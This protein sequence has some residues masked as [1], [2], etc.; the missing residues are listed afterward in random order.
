MSAFAVRVLSSLAGL[1]REQP[2]LARKPYDSREITL[3]LTAGLAL[4][5]GL[6]HIGAGVDH[7]REFALYT[8]VFSLLAVAQIAWAALLVWRPT[9]RWIALG[10]L[11]QVGIVALW[12]LSRTAGVPIAPKAWVPEEIGI[13]D[14]VETLCELV[15]V[16]AA[17]AVL[18]SSRSAAAR[19]LV[20]ALPAFLLVAV[21]AGALFGTGAHA[22]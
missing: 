16:F 1:E 21:L 2:A 20:A 8:L 10:C 13:A 11:L 14:S 5:C 19:R 22:G 6:I 7:F 17:V 12:V 9:P 4:I 18:A 15:T 3:R